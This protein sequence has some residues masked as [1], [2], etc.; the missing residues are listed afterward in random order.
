[1][2]SNA[3]RPL[4][5][6]ALGGARSAVRGLAG[7][8]SRRSGS[9]TRAQFRLCRAP[10]ATGRETCA[11]PSSCFGYT[12]KENSSPSYVFN[13]EENFYYLTG[14]NEEGAALLIVPAER[15]RKRLEGPQ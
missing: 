2:N 15:R 9:R 14:H 5:A 8:S 13:Q 12:G 7:D 10:R 3:G 1:M 4:G 11:H 6:C